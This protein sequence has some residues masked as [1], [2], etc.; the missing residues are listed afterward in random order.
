[1]NRLGVF[2]LDVSLGSEVEPARVKIAVQRFARDADGQVFI[3]PECSSFAE[4]EGQINA[5]QDE[6][7]RMNVHSRSCYYGNSKTVRMG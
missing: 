5:L 4:I 6:L 2:E 1:M 7:D 3:S